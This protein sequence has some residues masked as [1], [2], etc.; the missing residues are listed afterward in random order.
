[1]KNL[2]VS[3]P[4]A[5]YQ[6][7][8]L[9][10]ATMIAAAIIC[11]IGLALVGRGHL[12]TTARYFLAV[13]LASTCWLGSFAMMYAATTA[14]VAHA[15]SLL[16]HLFFSFIPAATFQFSVEYLG[17][18]GQLRWLTSLF[19]IIGLISGIAPFVTQAVP[20]VRRFAWGFYPQG[21]PL[22]A[23]LIASLVVTHFASIGFFTHAWRTGRGKSRERAGWVLVALLISGTAAVDYLPAQGVDLQPVS[24]LL[25][26]AFTA[27]AGAAIWRYGLSDLTPEYASAQILETMKGA[28]VVLDTNGYIRVINRAA[29]VLLKYD[30]RQLVGRHVR[31]IVHLPD[32]ADTSEM[33]G[34]HGVVEQEMEWRASDGSPI[35]VI[36]SASLVR[37]EDG[38]PAGLVYV[39]T[40]H[41]ERKRAE[42]A[43]R[44]SEHRYRTL[45][46]ANPL[47]MW[48]YDCETLAFVAVNDAAVRHYGY[49]REEFLAMSI[50][51][52]RP[53]EEVPGVRAILGN[54]SERRGPNL[55]R[56]RFKDGTIIDVEITSFS[57]TSAGKV[58]RLVMAQDVTLR[59]RAEN[60]LRES[61]Q[62]YRELFETA[63][64]LV[65]TLDG[66]GVITSINPA[67]TRITGYARSDFIGSEFRAFVAPEHLDRLAESLEKKLRRETESTFYE[68]DVI[69]RDG[70]RIPFELSTTLILRDGTFA[71]VQ[72]IARDVSERRENEARYRL[73][74]ERNLAGVYRTTANGEILDCN[75]ACARIFG[76]ANRE[77][78]LSA[79]AHS[80]Y[81]GKEERDALVQQLREQG[82]LSNVEM[83]F[84]RHDGS[85]VWV[86]EN[87]T[88]LPGRGG[89]GD[90]LEGTIIDIT[91]RKRA[92]SQVEYHAYHDTLTGL[93][94]RL[95]FRDRMAV[96]LSHA[97]RNTRSAAVMFLDLD[98]FKVVNDTLGHTVGDRLLQAIA[99]R[100]V[101][102]VRAEDTVSR[103]GGDEFTVLLSDLADRRGAAIVAEK[104]LEAVRHPVQ[105]DEHELYVS[106][107][108]GISIFPEDGDDVEALLKNADRAMY[109]AKELGRDNFQYAAALRYD[110]RL[111]L[112]KG[113]AQA[114]AAGEFVLH[115][116]PAVEVATGCMTAVEALLRWESP[117]YGLLRPDEF[118]SAAEDT[119][120]ILPLR[121]WTL[122]TACAQMKAWHDAGQTHLRVCVN[123][124]AR[125]FQQRDL[126]ATVAAILGETGLAPSALEIEIVESTAMQS[127]DLARAII[128]ALRAIG[129]RVAIDDFGSGSGT[130]NFL[131]K[132]AVDTIKIDPSF[133]R[134]VESGGAGAAVVEALIRMG[135]QL[136]LRVV[137]EGVETNGQHRFLLE[138]ECAEM[139]GHL[140]REAR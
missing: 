117:Q 27:V 81:Y 62:R 7:S 79:E 118:L 18:R 70:R 38:S 45:F 85:E 46:D 119:P 61:E 67:G 129:V 112:E 65:F 73:L 63:H 3:L 24:P 36:A 6:F 135:H 26:V 49:T 4:A 43:M 134:D 122:R 20:D 9:S 75:D 32:E 11:A 17:R 42:E 48:V 111:E 131:R 57:F 99:A 100:V 78:F 58:F 30:E 68:I 86:L 39:A 114:L 22:N 80:V 5:E 138:H 54:L 116:Q 123:L 2:Q 29:S 107:S 50:L 109:M 44:E 127:L 1:M 77:E 47:P 84:R 23:L 103:M 90:V 16:G 139:Q 51:D 31:G 133:V 97:R 108:I 92:Q 14:P 8:A 33:L 60:E 130:L 10:I 19:W 132:V 25:M 56:H 89:E 13:T 55:F 96:A 93:P 69:G 137:A 126:A 40:D 35:Q 136:G 37:L 59:H 91:D 74:F 71:G 94:N 140:H 128:T 105:I 121:D 115:Y 76:F 106:T 87:V 83:R 64:D 102:C 82:S 125:Q 95:L 34:S 88:L 15:W 120:V 53:E 124:S 21:T 110:G 113:L 101:N 72:V 66:D 104:I 12:R 52:I 98:Q 41:T 28:V